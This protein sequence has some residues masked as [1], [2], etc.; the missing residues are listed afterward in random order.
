MWEERH[1]GPNPLSPE[2]SQHE[3]LCL[4]VPLRLLWGWPHSDQLSLGDGRLVG[5]RDGGTVN[6]R[7]AAFSH[8]SEA[9]ISPGCGFQPSSGVPS[10]VPCLPIGAPFS[11]SQKGVVQANGAPFTSKPGL[12]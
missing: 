9:Q 1:V 3:H 7:L 12:P 10:A 11:N 4:T 6:M 2:G 8:H 5:W